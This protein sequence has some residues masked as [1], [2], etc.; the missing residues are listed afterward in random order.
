MLVI[1]VSIRADASELLEAPELYIVMN[2]FAVSIR[3]DASELLE[4]MADKRANYSAFTFQFALMR[5]ISSRA[6]KGWN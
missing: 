2:K 3:A 5:V 6:K 1:K 4:G